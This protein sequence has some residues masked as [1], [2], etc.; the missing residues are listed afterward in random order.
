METRS[1]SPSNVNAL[2]PRESGE[3]LHLFTSG[4]T[5]IGRGQGLLLL[6]KAHYVDVVGPNAMVGGVVDYTCRQLLLLGSLHLVRPQGYAERQAAF[7]ERLVWIDYLSNLA[8]E[9]VPLQRAQACLQKLV[10]IAG[11][12]AIANLSNDWLGRIC[13]VLPTTMVLARQ[14][15]GLGNST[16]AKPPTRHRSVNPLISPGSHGCVTGM[17]GGYS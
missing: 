12:A 2:I 3:L 1:G 14:S 16:Q 13:G 4:Q 9:T 10:E 8:V 11:A 7:N 17:S 15:V 5:L 6:V